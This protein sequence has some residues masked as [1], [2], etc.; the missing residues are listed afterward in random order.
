MA[1]LYSLSVS[2]SIKQSCVYQGGYDLETPYAGEY[3]NN[4]LENMF[5][6]EDVYMYQEV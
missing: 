4:L 5:L 6:F 2:L 1:T 3:I